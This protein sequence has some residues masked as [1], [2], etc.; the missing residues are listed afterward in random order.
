MIILDLRNT[1][2]DCFII[3]FLVSATQKS[4]NKS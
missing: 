4:Y 2:P 3:E 1:D